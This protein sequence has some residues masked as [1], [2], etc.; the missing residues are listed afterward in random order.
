MKLIR[1]LFFLMMMCGAMPLQAQQDDTDSRGRFSLGFSRNAYRGD[2]GDSYGAGRAA[3]HLSYQFAHQKRLHGGLHLGAGSLSGQ[4]VRIATPGPEDILLANRFFQ[5][6][7]F[8]FHYALQY[9]IFRYRGLLL[10]A[11]QGIGLMRFVPKDE[12]GADLQDQLS[13]R[14]ENESYGNATAILPTQI[15]IE[16]IFD[17]HFGFGLQAGWFNTTTDYLDNISRLGN[18]EGGDNVWQW[19]FRFHIPF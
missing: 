6:S 12:F 16:Y 7:F 19:H 11:S 4:E 15:G 14:A 18:R 5:T 1:L 2:L 8:S 13:T 10:Y 9:D 17:N 3:F